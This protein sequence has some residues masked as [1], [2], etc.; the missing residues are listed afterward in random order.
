[1]KNQ[2]KMQ[3]NQYIRIPSIIIFS[4][5]ML[6][7]GLKRENK[8]MIIK[9]Y[10]FT[11]INRYPKDKVIEYDIEMKKL[12]VLRLPSKLQSSILFSFGYLILVTIILYLL[13]LSSFIAKL[14]ASLYLLYMIFCFVLI[15][16]GSMG[17]DYRFSTGLSHYLEDFFLSPFFVL[18]LGVIIKAFGFTS[19]PSNKKS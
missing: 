16:I 5:M 18:A 14:T 3:K 10:Q 1:M 12:K 13:S 8:L 9:D 19:S 6:W 17:V 2:I 11:F 7:L 15:K 4:L